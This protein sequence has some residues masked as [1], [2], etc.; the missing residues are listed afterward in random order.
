MTEFYL[1]RHGE[2]KLNNTSDT[3]QDRIRG[4][5]DVPLDDNGRK[6]AKETAKQLIDSPITNLITSD[7]SRARETADIIGKQLK[8]KPTPTQ[9][10]R[11]WDLGNLTGKSTKEVIP[12]IMDYLEYPDEP[13]PKGESF[14]SF[15]QRA[16]N[17]L[18]DALEQSNGGTLGAVTHHR[19]ERLIKAWIANGQPKDGEIDHD[20]FT[21]KGEDPG[22]AELISIK[23]TN[24]RS[25]RKETPR[26]TI[27]RAIKE[28]H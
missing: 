6:T 23:D 18:L 17:G 14:N 2:T 15:K 19:V 11:P 20:V 8:L 13:V 16:F 7:L 27:E 12:Q 22:K 3:S 1:I 21:Q 10:L 28:A 25:M 26:N 5:S 24:L 9:G 4:W